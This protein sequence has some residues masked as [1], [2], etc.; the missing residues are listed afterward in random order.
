MMVVLGRWGGCRC[1]WFVPMSRT[2]GTVLVKRPRRWI[3]QDAKRRM[4]YGWDLASGDVDTWG[5]KGEVRMD[6]NMSR[7]EEEMLPHSFSTLHALRRE[8]DE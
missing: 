2:G 4:G 1:V 5:S 7:E 8:E 3:T 6:V